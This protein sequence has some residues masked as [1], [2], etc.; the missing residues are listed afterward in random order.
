MTALDDEAPDRSQLHAHQASAYRA[1]AWYS[2]STARAGRDAASDDSGLALDLGACDQILRKTRMVALGRHRC[3][4]EHLRFAH[5]G[6]QM[7][8]A[9]IAFR[10]TS[11]RLRIGAASAEVV[12]PNH[13]TLHNPGE[14]YVR[15]AV[16]AEGDDHDW[17]ALVAA[18]GSPSWTADPA[19]ASCVGR[20]A[21]RG[22]IDAHLAS[23]TISSCV[24]PAAD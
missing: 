6:G 11:V 23:W 8:C 3:A 10:R 22:S 7:A 24:S 18:L 19:F 12:S 16:S 4:V 5:G 1:S 15:E 2:P 21:N 13:V 9:R 14:S 17:L 20:Q